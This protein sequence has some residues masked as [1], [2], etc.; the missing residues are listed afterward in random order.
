[1]VW[2]NAGIIAGLCDLLTF[3]V[4]VKEALFT[5]TLSVP[6]TVVD[7][8]TFVAGHTDVLAGFPATVGAPFKFAFSI[9]QTIIFFAFSVAWL[10]LK[11][12]YSV[13]LPG[14]NTCQHVPTR[15]IVEEIPSIR[16]FT[17]ARFFL[18]L[19]FPIA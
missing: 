2:C 16:A 3:S 6:K 4:T 9:L 17:T 8:T 13:T 1:M 11:L 7:G 14:S 19:S 10:Y 18:I 12:C 15:S 5:F